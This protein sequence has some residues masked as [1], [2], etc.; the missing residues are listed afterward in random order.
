MN[1]DF[2]FNDKYNA[3]SADVPQTNVNSAQNGYTSP[4]QSHVQPQAVQPQHSQASSYQAVQPQHSQSGGYQTGQSQYSQANRYQ[5]PQPQ[6]SQPN[7]QQQTQQRSFSQKPFD[8]GVETQNNAAVQTNVAY[9]QNS[10]PPVNN[11]YQYNNVYQSPQG[12]T[13]QQNDY[14]RYYYA[15]S[16]TQLEKEEIKKSS[17]FAGKTTL[18]LFLVMEGLA[19]IV[20]AI[21]MACG[22]MNLSASESDPYMG[23]TATGYYLFSGM[24]SLVSIFIPTLILFKMS[25]S[26]MEELVPFKRVEGKKLAAI[27]T[28]S[29][30][31]SMLA[32]IIVALINVNFSIFGIDIY[33]GLESETPTGVFD[34]IMNTICTAVIPALVEEFAYRGLVIGVLKKHGDLFAV[35]TSAFLFGMLHGN[36]A[37]IPFAFVLGLFLGYVR[38]K[39][40]SMLPSILIHF[41]NNFYAV[42]MTTLSG[43]LSEEMGYVVDSATM[44]ILIVIGFIAISYLAKNHKDFFKTKDKESLLTFKG[45]MKTFFSTGTVIANII[46]LS[47]SALLLLCI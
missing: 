5:T 26:T 7:Q 20:Y 38:V 47:A 44:I 15:P 37:Q 6:Y 18:A 13:P 17:S 9:Q 43:T 28:G 40:D 22:A 30:A 29:L 11:T 4:Q 24:L 25:G 32:Q 10:T 45:K 23:F 46:I 19:F 2:T 31:L 1:E 39:T 16:P 42:I 34:F 12:Y 21:A 8:F 3:D 33:S 36:L 14:Y 41:G 35:V 27:V